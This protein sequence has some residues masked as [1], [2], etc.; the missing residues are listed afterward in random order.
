MRPRKL[1]FTGSSIHGSSY[2]SL[3]V[4]ASLVIFQPVRILL[5][6]SFEVFAEIEISLPIENLRLEFRMDVIIHLHFR[7]TFY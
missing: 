7:R 6:F 3:P 1:E 2:Y 5:P 4:S